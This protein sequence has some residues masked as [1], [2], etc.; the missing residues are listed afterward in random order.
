MAHSEN[1]HTYFFEQVQKRE[2]ANQRVD[3]DS[4]KN[5]LSVQSAT[6]R[7]LLCKEEFLKLTECSDF[8]TV[9]DEIE[10]ISKQKEEERKRMKDAW[11]H[12]KEE[13][14]KIRKNTEKVLAEI[15]QIQQ[16]IERQRLHFDRISSEGD[17]LQSKGQQS[18]NHLKL[19]TKYDIEQLL[20]E[21]SCKEML[22]GQQ[23]TLETVIRDIDTDQMAVESEKEITAKL[24]KES[25]ALK[26]KERTHRD[27]LSLRSQH[28]RSQGANAQI[29]T[30][31]NGRYRENRE[32]ESVALRQELQ[33]MKKLLMIRTLVVERDEVRLQVESASN[34]EHV[35]D[36]HI[37]LGSESGSGSQPDAVKIRSVSVTQNGTSYPVGEWLLSRYRQSESEQ[38]KIDSP[39]VSIK[40]MVRG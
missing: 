23:Q 21:N 8:N 20:T 35:Y 1:D 32:M 30:A 19:G 22:N 7:N 6:Y 40:Q 27:A 9:F 5:L 13:K 31:S 3:L 26:L 17:A 39:A 24:T 29:V 11:T 12:K 25:E 33:S 14:R 4:A 34:G 16:E 36:I 38:Q 2:N 15:A 18:I 10:T 37:A 28:G